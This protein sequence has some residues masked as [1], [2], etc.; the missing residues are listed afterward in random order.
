VLDG[1]VK[2]ST[3][4][5]FFAKAYPERYF[6]CWIAEQNMVGVA[7]GLAAEGKIPFVSSFAAFLSRAGDFI[8]MA[9][10]QPA[11]ASGVLRQP[12]RRFDR[13]GRAVADGAGRYRPVPRLAGQ[14]GVVSLRCGQ[15]ERG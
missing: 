1:D 3:Y 12:R 2:N 5:E 8:R 6:E 7:L 10:A 4:A 14:H 15:R 9:G 13:R 11:E